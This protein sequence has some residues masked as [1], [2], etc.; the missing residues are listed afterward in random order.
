MCGGGRIPSP[1]HFG[2]TSLRVL[3]LALVA[4][5]TIVLAACASVPPATVGTAT[6]SPTEWPM[7]TKPP[8]L[9]AGPQETRPLPPPTYVRWAIDKSV[10]PARPYLLDFFYDGYANGFTVF[11]SSGQVAFRVPISG[12]K[13]GPESCV[14]RARQDGKREDSSWL[15]VG[16]GGMDAVTLERFIRDPGSYRVEA[17]GVD[18][19]A[20][21]IPHSDSGCRPL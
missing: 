3:A 9:L 16:A 14:A 8:H 7:I 2:M 15:L 10:D 17:N 5:G 4:I 20:V 11:D 6:A 13:P 1:H 21:T 19:R 18:G 12:G